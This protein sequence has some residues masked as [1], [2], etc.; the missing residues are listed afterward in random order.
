MRKPL[1]IGTIGVNFLVA[2]GGYG[3]LDLFSDWRRT[4]MAFLTVIAFAAI[5]H[6]LYKRAHAAGYL[7]TRGPNWSAYI[8]AVRVRPSV[9]SPLV[10]KSR[11]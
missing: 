3:F 6:H 11:N 2:P 10:M 9:T 1:L 7:P 4:V 5:G 8:A